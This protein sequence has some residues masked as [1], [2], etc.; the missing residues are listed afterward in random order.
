M[1]K[2]LKVLSYGKVQ[3]ADWTETGWNE[4][5]VKD[6]VT[7]I[8]YWN[9]YKKDGCEGL[10][11]AWHMETYYRTYLRARSNQQKSELK[12]NYLISRS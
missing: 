7:N 9:I 8:Y 2:L 11:T 12:E 3:G 1:N 10:G 4:Q 6:I 5:A